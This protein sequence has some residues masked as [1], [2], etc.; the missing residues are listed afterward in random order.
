M[1]DPLLAVENLHTHFRTD[2]GN[3][4]AVDGVS[5][6]VDR[7]ET[8]ALVGESGSGKTV[9]AESITRLFQNPPG[10]I[11][12]GSVTVDG[13]AV[14]TMGE[15]ELR[16]LRGGTVSHVFQ[17]P[18]G[19][20]NPVYTV[21]WQLREALTL[22]QNLS[23]DA[24]TEQAVELLASVG[25]PEAGSR[26]D[27]YPHELSGGQRQRVMIAIALACEPAL[28][29]ADEPTTALDVTIQAQ[30]L[31]LLRD[32]QER[33]EMAMLFVTH[34]LGVVAE[35]A[36][37]VVVMYAG[38]VMERGPVEAIFEQP[39]HPYT[40]AL[41]SCLPGQG[42]LQ[43]IPGDLPNPKSPPDGCRFAPR[44]PHAIEGCEQGD[45]PPL[46]QVGDDHVAS[47]VHFGPGGDAERVLDTDTLAELSGGHEP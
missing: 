45:Q 35:L 44:C 2:D 4:R 32:V 37:R 22:H 20:L 8:V 6:T 13:A 42:E 29:I 16:A 15:D 17:N 14:T 47:C 33:R 28:L 11:P 12:E 36:D 7:G 24:A 23:A 27:D 25:L 43:G 30:I 31:S 18:E 26:L 21:G 3:L 41:L 38:K 40:R 5:F 46:H 1:T 19:A 34:D 9:T 10:Y 39:A